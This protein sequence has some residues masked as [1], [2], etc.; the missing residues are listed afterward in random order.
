MLKS[1]SSAVS[2]AVV[3]WRHFIE[4]VRMGVLRLGVLYIPGYYLLAEE[5]YSSILLL[6]ILLLLFNCVIKTADVT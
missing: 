6:W 5:V 2:P 1:F 3:V 4:S